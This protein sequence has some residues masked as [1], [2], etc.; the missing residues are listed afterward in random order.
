MTF[1]ITVVFFGCL[2]NLTK[3]SP[4]KSGN[5]V[6]FL[7]S[8]SSIFC[9]LTFLFRN[10]FIMQSMSMRKEHIYVNIVK[11]ADNARIICG[12]AIICM[13]AGLLRMLSLKKRLKNNH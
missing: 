1:A 7:V 10:V 9:S 4:D 3:K 12:R 8:L 2:F 6:F 13:R 11:R 5:F